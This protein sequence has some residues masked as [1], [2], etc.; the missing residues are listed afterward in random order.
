MSP[1]TVESNK[2]SALVYRETCGLAW[3]SRDD[4]VDVPSTKYWY[5]MAFVLITGQEW[6]HARPAFHFLKA[7]KHPILPPLPE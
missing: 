2:L 1:I 6:H 4:A 7:L 3:H 5:G